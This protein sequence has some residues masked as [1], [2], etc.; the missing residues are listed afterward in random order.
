M[1]KVRPNSTTM[2]EGPVNTIEE[3]VIG[4]KMK[5]RIKGC[6]VSLLGKFFIKFSTVWELVISV[7]EGR[8]S[9]I[10][11]GGNFTGCVKTCYTDNTSFLN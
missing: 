1:V 9:L 7:F 3:L 8:V 11:G 5:S 6:I 4:M 2:E 10:F